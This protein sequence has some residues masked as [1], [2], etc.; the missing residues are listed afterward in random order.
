MLQ[1][2]LELP[3]YALGEVNHLLSEFWHFHRELTPVSCPQCAVAC[4][5]E[6]QYGLLC[7]EALR[8]RY[9]FLLCL[10]VVAH[11]LIHA[12]LLQVHY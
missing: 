9:V 12:S 5:F 10:K 4:A 1:L 7:D 2:A 11:Y 8:K 6:V 3:S